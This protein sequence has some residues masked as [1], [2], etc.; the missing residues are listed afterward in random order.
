MVDITL[1]AIIRR[2]LVAMGL[3]IHYYVNML[4]L[5]RRGLQELHFDTLQKV[6]HAVLSVDSANEATL[7]TDY[8]ESVYVGIEVGDKVRHIGDSGRINKRDNSGVAFDQVNN[9]YRYAFGSPGADLFFF[10]E[11]GQF[12][13]GQFGRNTTWTD[14]YTINRDLGILRVDNKSNITSVH[15]V[16]LSLPEK[17]TNRSVVHPFAEQALTD[18]VSWKWAEYTK[19]KMLGYYKSLFYNAHR[20]LRGRKN[21]MT[22]VEIKRSIRR[23]T[24]LSVKG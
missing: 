1:D 22:T 17:V 9:Q 7:P 20:I 24:R 11:F 8:V 15:L 19:D 12:I 23:N 21:K 6:K 18:W 4:V 3:P 13:S 2:N 5:A 16:Y 10:D 14:D